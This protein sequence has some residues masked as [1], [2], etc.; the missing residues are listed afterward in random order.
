[1]IYGTPALNIAN[2]T[3]DRIGIRTLILSLIWQASRWPMPIEE[4]DAEAPPVPEVPGGLMFIGKQDQQRG[5]GMRR[6]WTFE[7]VD[8]DGKSVT[9]KQRHN[10][11]DYA[12]APGFSQVSIL[13]HNNIQSLLDTYG[14]SVFE[15]E[16]LF[17]PTISGTTE[18]GL[19]STGG[20]EKANPMFGV[21][22]FLRSEGT[23]TYR[24]AARDESE[25]PDVE[26]KLFTSGE[27]PGRPRRYKDR[28]W[29]C[30]GAPYQRRG[31][32]LEV[33]EIYWLSGPGGWPK[34]IYKG[35]AA[36]K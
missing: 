18:T 14:G 6:I 20:E 30:A 34:P 32:V 15:G 28:N 24:Y 3:T 12:F 11:P 23:Y 22:D 10:S 2:D 35:G 25:I 19:G 33:Q 9:F 13:L 21:K 7:G 5:G 27:L 4:L 29:L 31:P 8:G 16:V 1:M 26:G 17:P 36:L